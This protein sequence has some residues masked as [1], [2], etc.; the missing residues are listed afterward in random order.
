MVFRRQVPLLG[1]CIVDFLAPGAR[2]IVEVD[3]PYH[4]VPARRRADE[5]RDQRLSKAGYRVLRLTAQQVLK[6][7]E[8]VRALVLGALAERP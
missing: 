3:G 7:P 4:A 5:R 1:R 8:V 2:L 6:Q